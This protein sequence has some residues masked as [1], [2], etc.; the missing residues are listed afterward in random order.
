MVHVPKP[1]SAAALGL[2]V[3]I[4]ATGCP[5]PDPNPPMKVTGDISEAIPSTTE[6]P[7]T[8]A[9]EATTTTLFYP[10]LSTP[11]TVAEGGDAE[12]ATTTTVAE[13]GAGDSGV[14]TTTEAE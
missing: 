12:A 5:H 9:A 14:T 13:E 10:G 1:L 6:P 8:T 4:S 11:T 2:L 3:A 7:T